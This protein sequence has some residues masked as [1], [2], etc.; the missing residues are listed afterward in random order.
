MSWHFLQCPRVAIRVTEV[1]ILY[2]PQ[3]VNLTYFNAPASE[4]FAGLDNVCYYQMQG[5]YGS[6]LHF[7]NFAQ[8][9]SDD[10]RTSRPGRCKLD[11]SHSVTRLDV[12]VY[13]KPDLFN[14]E[15]LGAVNIRNRDWHNLKFHIHFSSCSFALTLMGVLL[16]L[17]LSDFVRTC[18]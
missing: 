17:W 11:D 6:R 2:A 3:I 16:W 4:R 13:I 18:V 9:G 1:D 15:G 7:R 14:V 5:L 10:D 8:T 12:K